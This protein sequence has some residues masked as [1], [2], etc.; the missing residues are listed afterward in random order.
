MKPPLQ[1]VMIEMFD[2]LQPI[3]NTKRKHKIANTLGET[4]NC[5]THIHDLIQF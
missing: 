5:F 2:L 4:K 1:G 3:C